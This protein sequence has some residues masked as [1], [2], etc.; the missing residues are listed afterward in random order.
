MTVPDH[1]ESMSS[2]KQAALLD[3]MA[4]GT[5]LVPTA[6]GWHRL[7]SSLCFGQQQ[8]R[9]CGWEVLPV[10]LRW[11][12]C[13][14]AVVE[15]LARSG[16]TVPAKNAA[17]PGAARA[18]AKAALDDLASRLAADGNP[19][20]ERLLADLRLCGQQQQELRES[21]QLDH[22]GSTIGDDLERL[23]AGSLH[24]LHHLAD[25]W[26]QMSKAA[27]QE[28]QA[29]TRNGTRKFDS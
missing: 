27:P 24:A 16:A 9:C 21:G 3:S 10:W 6:L 5:V 11:P 12:R 14:L 19:L 29:R 2:L 8:S 26:D 1:N 25:L 13:W 17:G 7:A 4:H 22:L 15:T 18:A 23:I 28:C 20:T